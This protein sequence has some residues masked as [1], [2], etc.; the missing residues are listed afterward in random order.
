MSTRQIVDEIEKL[1][2]DEKIKLM[3]VMVMRIAKE[4][5]QAGSLHKGA[6]VLL[7]DY[8][9]DKELTVFTSLDKENF[10]ETR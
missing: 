6:E 1:P 10:Y 2:L 4:K 7:S 8:E 9:N 5:E 3:Q